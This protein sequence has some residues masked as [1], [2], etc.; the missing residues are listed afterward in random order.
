MAN[1]KMFCFGGLPQLSRFV[2]AVQIPC[3]S[4]LIQFIVTFYAK[5][6]IVLRKGRQN[7][8]TEARFG[9]F[10]NVLLWGAATVQ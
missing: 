5:F 4:K 3:T 1:S 8:Q 9:Q 2:C 6:V 10:K 7:K